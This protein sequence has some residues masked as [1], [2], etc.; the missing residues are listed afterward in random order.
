V[1]RE[2][3][4]FHFIGGLVCQSRLDNEHA[5]Y[6]RK[7]FNA[8]QLNFGCF[9]WLAGFFCVPFGRS[10]CVTSPNVPPF[11]ILTTTC[12]DSLWISWLKLTSH[13]S[14]GLRKPW[15]WLG[16]LARLS[17]RSRPL[18]DFFCVSPSAPRTIKPKKCSREV[19]EFLSRRSWP[20]GRRSFPKVLLIDSRT[21]LDA[22]N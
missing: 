4:N 3:R 17:R 11:R 1:R 12:R 19:V 14:R 5:N 10:S 2:K 15:R 22:N 18:R 20:V 21:R 6:D 8:Q 9:C 16:H 7:R 13:E